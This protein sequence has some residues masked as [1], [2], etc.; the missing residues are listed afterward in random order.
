MM[1]IETIYDVLGSACASPP[2]D[3]RAKMIN[4]FYVSFGIPFTLFFVQTTR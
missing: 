4:V 3:V 1:M 2:I